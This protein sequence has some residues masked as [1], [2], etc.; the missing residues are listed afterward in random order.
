MD[1]CIYWVSTLGYAV[2]ALTILLKERKYGI[3]IKKVNTAVTFMLATSLAFYLV[4]TLWGLCS[5]GIIHNDIVFFI[6]SSLF[7]SLGILM[8][9][10]WL[11][12]ILIYIRC[13]KRYFYPIIWLDSMI[14]AV[15][16]V[17]VFANFFTPLLFTVKDGVYTRETLGVYMFVNQNIVFV[18]SAIISLLALLFKRSKKTAHTK[19]LAVF[20]ASITPLVLGVIQLMQP[21]GPYVSMGFALSTTLL[22]TFVISTDREEL[23]LS[24]VTF[25]RNMSHEIRTSLNSVYGFAQLLGM[26]ENTWSEE[27]REKYNEYMHNNYN[28]LNLLLNDLMAYTRFEK[29]D[30]KI[31]IGQI[32]VAK[33]CLN[34]VQQFEACKPTSL[35]VRT[36]LELPEN[37]KIENDGLRIQQILVNLLANASQYT[38]IGEITLH[39]SLSDEGLELAVESPNV[40]FSDSKPVTMG[41]AQDEE[42]TTELLGLRISVCRII[43]KLLGGR[44]FLD[45]TYTKGERIVLVINHIY[46]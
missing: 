36:V 23:H 13:P 39:A 28:M 12:Y 41:V 31:N 7:H 8:A 5:Y 30:Y 18:G 1:N 27:E 24:K 43:S 11:Y 34:A 37:M 19:H 2:L 22:Y 46:Q 15:D 3:R 29:K 4:D 44:V 42:D 9:F 14:V 25:L 26:P 38:E 35:N 16:T 40:S 20:C 17:L 6:A 32:D 21:N 10:A 33:T 45:R